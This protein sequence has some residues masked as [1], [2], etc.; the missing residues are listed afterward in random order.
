MEQGTILNIQR[1]STED[2]PGIRTTVFFK[3][4]TLSCKWCHNPESI[5]FEQE[6]EWFVNKC[7]GCRT[8]EVSCSSSAISFSDNKL[9]ID[10]NKCK[11]CMEC[12]V[13]CPTNALEA[14][15]RHWMTDEIYNELIKDAAFFNDGGGITLSGG[16]VLA[17]SEFAYKVLKKLKDKRIHT[18]VDTCG[19]IKFD[20]IEKVVNVT[21][22]FLFDIKIMNSA[23]HKKY[24]GAENKL[25]L[26]NYSKLAKKVRED[27]STKIWVRTPLIP[28]ITDTDENIRAIAEF[29]CNIGTD[30]L[31]RWELLAFNNLCESKYERLN[32][33]WEFHNVPGQDAEK[34]DKINKIINDYKEL[35]GIAFVTGT[36]SKM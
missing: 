26:D 17:Q 14:K 8:C 2:G 19:C 36:G 10:K 13:T 21:S 11:K 35:N 7:I 15:G 6:H 22:L 27:G 33:E 31:E 34:L 28:D 32:K 25:I 30:V 3:G 23:L 4:C 9:M 12:T 18:A 29:I 1:M 5:N 16:E 24:T 20:N